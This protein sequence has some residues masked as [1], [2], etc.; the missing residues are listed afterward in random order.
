MAKFVIN[1]AATRAARASLISTLEIVERTTIVGVEEI[2]QK[3]W[4]LVLHSEGKERSVV[5]EGGD[6]L[7][8]CQGKAATV[9]AN[10]EAAT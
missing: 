1:S 10:L 4:L 8:E 5:F 9:L 6:T 2:E 7:E 3:S